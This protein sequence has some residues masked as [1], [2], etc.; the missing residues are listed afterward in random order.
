MRRLLVTSYVFLP[1]MI[2]TNTAQRHLSF[3]LINTIVS[4]SFSAARTTMASHDYWKTMF[5]TKSYSHASPSLKASHLR[6]S[7]PVSLFIRAGL[8]P[9]SEIKSSWSHLP[10]LLG[11]S[12]ATILSRHTM[13]FQHATRIIHLQNPLPLE[14]LQ[15]K[16]PSPLGQARPRL[17]L[18]CQ[19]HRQ[20]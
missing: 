3:M 19:R 9:S 15:S 8:A 4:I 17:P 14:M 12:S 13:R 16:H 18:P 6:K 5:T 2:H 1:L 7:S 10:C 20:M 11:P